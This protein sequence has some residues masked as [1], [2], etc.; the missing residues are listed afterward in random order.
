MKANS[1]IAIFLLALLLG[2][3]NCSKVG[4]TPAENPDGSEGVTCVE[5]KKLG[6]WLANGTFLGDIVTYSGNL[7]AEAN[8]NYY[9]ASA[10]P[11][12]GPDPTGYELHNF[13]YEGS[14]G[15]VLNFYG[16]IDSNDNTDGSPDHQ[17]SIKIS[18]K[19]N[20]QLDNVVFV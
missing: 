2:F 4:F 12:K 11:L 8:Y 17:Y 20:G 19:G 3:Q 16:N 14:D 5:G 10:H 18:T 7:S 1:L 13:F 6:I 15:L 9:S